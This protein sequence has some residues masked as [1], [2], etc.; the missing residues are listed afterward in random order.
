MARGGGERR[1]SPS[2]ID[3][4]FTAHRHSTM[5]STQTSSP[6]ITAYALFRGKPLN[7]KPLNL[8]LGPIWDFPKIRVPYLGV[9]MIRIL[10]F[11]VLY[12]G[13]LFSEAPICRLPQEEKCDSAVASSL[14]AVC[15]LAL[16]LFR[17]SFQESTGSS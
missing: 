13:P 5:H 14:L 15:F 7:P 3:R 17:G 11:R 9:L 4:L 12:W 10:L 16:R 6:D 1:K 2:F 8:T